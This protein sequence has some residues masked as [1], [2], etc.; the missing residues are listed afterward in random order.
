MATE[1]KINE[2]DNLQLKWQQM[3]DSALSIE[4]DRLKAELN[5]LKEKRLKLEKQI[6]GKESRRLT[7][8]KEYLKG[9]IAEQDLNTCELQQLDRY[10][11][12]KDISEEEHIATLESLGYDELTFDKLKWMP[13]YQSNDDECVVCYEPPK[14]HM[15]IPC[16]HICL[17]YD[18]AEDSFQYNQIDQISVN[19]D[20][21]PS[22]V[23]GYIEAC[24]KKGDHIPADLI[25]LIV[26]Y[27][28]I[29]KFEWDCPLCSW[30]ILAVKQ[31][32]F[33]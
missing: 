27:S 33:F 20:D 31:V 11:H 18:C 9:L 2:E 6:E 5:S 29:P 4:I 23:H 7:L 12:S 10:K 22:L 3:S 21:L 32:Y 16:N 25:L 14:D 30:E 8:Y 1:G 13:Y 26:K 17:C 15:L 19:N 24:Y 28:K